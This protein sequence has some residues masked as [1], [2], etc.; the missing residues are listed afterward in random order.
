[1]QVFV[2]GMHRSGTSALAR[3][4]NLMG[5][6]FG[7]ENVNTGRSEENLKGFWER[8]DVRT[9][10]DTILFNAGCDWDRVS[11]L[12]LDA[13]PEDSK[14][15]YR[16]MATDIVMN[17]DAHRPWFMKE[18]RFCVLFPIWRAATE[19]PVC[20][21]IH[22][23]PLE[24]SSSLKSRNDTSIRVGLA[25]WELYNVRAL[26]ASAGVPR[27]FLS[28]EALMKK[29]VQTVESIHAALA[30][31]GSYR[32]RM[33][34]E[35]ELASF[36]DEKLHRQ[37]ES[38]ESLRAVATG[39]QLAL[40]DHLE[41]ATSNPDAVATPVL[42]NDSLDTLGKYEEGIDVAD[43]IE[44]ANVRQ[45]QRSAANLELQIALKKLELKH[46]LSSLRNTSARSRAFE[47]KADQ[48]R[49]AETNLKIEL[50]VGGQRANT[51]ERDRDRLER[52]G[53]ELSRANASL[54]RDR[55]RLERE[56]GQLERKG[57]E[58]SR[59]NAG[60]ERDRDRLERE[61]GQLERKGAELSRANASLERD[62]DR[63]EQERGRLERKGAEL[64]RANAS[65]DR[66]RDRLERDRGQLERKGAELG[67]ANAGLERDRDRLERERG[68][69][70]R[71]NVG[72]RS[73]IHKAAHEASNRRT[74]VLDAIRHHDMRLAYKKAKVSELKK[75]ADHLAS[76]IHDLL[77]SRRWRIGA[78]LLSLR[79]RLLFRNTPPTVQD[80]LS[81]AISTH[82]AKRH[83]YRDV[84]SYQ[85]S[86]LDEFQ[87]RVPGQT[88]AISKIIRSDMD[89]DIKLTG[90]L[91]EREMESKRR[92]QEIV[93][94]NEFVE[95][96][97]EVVEALTASRRWRL[98]HSLLSLPSRLLL[99]GA[100]PT[101][102]NSMAEF[103]AE[104]RLNSQS[105]TA[106]LPK[107]ALTKPVVSARENGS[108]ESALAN[109]PDEA[110]DKPIR[111]SE[112]ADVDPSIFDTTVDIVVCVHN[113]LDD[114]ERCL[115]SVI[116]K[117]TVDYHLIV[118]NDG[119]DT[120]TTTRL[121]Q[122]AAKHRMTDLIETNGPLGYTFAANRGLRASTA[123]NVVLLNSDTIVPRL[124]LESMLECMEYDANIGIVGPL[125][126]AASWQSIPDRFDDRGGWAVNELP[127]GYN[128][129]EFAELVH[130]ASERKFPY[131]DF[132]NGFCLMINRDVIN[133]IGYLDEA[134]FPRGYGEEND[135]CLRARDAGFD[136]A[137]ADQC[138]VY[139]AKSKS[140]GSATRDVL[141]KKGGESLRDKYGSS[142]IQVGTERLKNS[143]ELA[144]IRSQVDA[145]LD[146][147]GG[148]VHVGKVSAYRKPNRIL[149]VLPVKG[150]SGGANSVIQEAAGLRSMGIDAKVA[151][152]IKYMDGFRRFYRKF[153][154]SGEHFVFYDS[155]DSLLAQAE[156]FD[157]VVAT[158]WSTPALILPIA[159][160]WP[161]KLYAYYIQDYEPWFFTNDP[162]SRSVAFDSY[163]ILP[164]M[165]LMAKTD[166]MCRTV[167]ERHGCHVYR[168]A[169]SLDH[170]VYFPGI[171][172]NAM[173]ETV[174]VAAMIRP[175]TPRRAPLRTLRVLR[176]TVAN[177]KR[178]IR[179]LL[180][181]CETRDMK[182]YVEKHDPNLRL[183]FKFDNRG[184][185]T[186]EE[187]ADVLRSA[188]IFIDLSDYQAF[189]RTGL[190]AMACGCAVMLPA[191][192][193]V[194]EYAV[195]GDNACIVDTASFNDMTSALGRLIEDQALR[196]RM[197]HRG[198]E[199]ASRYSILRASFSELSVFRLAWLL[200]KTKRDPGSTAF[201]R[202]QEPV[203]VQE[204]KV[205]IG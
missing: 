157:V 16:S 166:W 93:E 66:D 145:F 51:I 198:I 53:A 2:L 10:N 176:E 131:V 197:Q 29:P 82:Y 194:Y 56:R 179:I 62:R 188:D 81:E 20:I 158:L 169:P 113:A 15:A 35:R 104:L 100:P 96:L 17:M 70:E 140:F 30:E 156:P 69:L 120:E 124:W 178:H 148:T 174:S 133:H 92:T 89:R 147:K 3:I 114:A 143:P 127:P 153:L 12:N 202:G 117:T 14:D 85:I 190:E 138:F 205:S 162:E 111:R 5:L 79:F 86:L 1:M 152:H 191:S 185:L 37:H 60:L 161:D 48:L 19:V 32:L 76:G 159:M 7:G 170:D 160:R 23:N 80:R 49:E 155:D 97:I 27:L 195:D 6:Y 187:V 184:L 146:A 165:T 39:S 65:L 41:G 103:I 150:G 18:P 78:A 71:A 122:L 154:D 57:A 123:E 106:K 181:G 107:M 132:V 139:H 45:R 102:A 28:Y 177:A 101:A 38:V 58:L 186:R 11:T 55:D 201:G 88:K 109:H 50:A 193:G 95:C 164:D 173:H 54:E 196:E 112:E 167:H 61:R 40:Y 68:Q 137:I 47:R 121:R 118:V 83:A 115:A 141:A 129:D 73:S 24:V 110:M 87:T 200:K 135:Y 9:L 94:L 46:A 172:S 64:G 36:L 163:T 144:R 63:L 74:E 136:L 116:A 151:T 98:G 21:H 8:R 182:S 183:D 52:K 105:E 4:L 72:L 189:G 149:Y 171:A 13:L 90:M 44:S 126:N 168:I 75:I 33:P 199:T 142:R 91:L 125:S 203:F 204:E 25:L 43:R 42:S 130:A 31:Q 22:R 192:G 180:F 67:R 119:S 134:T 128:V 26:E 108:G 59:A 77:H 175:S 84:A 99:W 34:S